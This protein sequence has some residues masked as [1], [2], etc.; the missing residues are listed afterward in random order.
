MKKPK[1]VK[2]RREPA[3]RRLLLSI[4]VIVAV[5]ICAVALVL[6]FSPPHEELSQQSEQPKAALLDTLEPNPTFTG[7]VVECLEE[8]GYEVDIYTGEEVTVELLENF[9]KGYALIIFRLH[10]ALYEDEGL[11]IFT[12]EPYSTREY[13]REQLA[14]EVKEALVYEG[15]E[16]FFAISQ[17]FVKHYMKGKIGD[18]IIVAM[19]CHTMA[20][21]LMPNQFIHQGAK[22][23]IGWSGL[24]TLSH[25][26]E[27]VSRLLENLCDENLTVGE[28]VNATATEVG[29]DP[30]YGTQL[31]YQQAEKYS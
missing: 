4:S 31:L 13:V 27:A 18:A 7:K 22:A 15:G 21:P 2:M 12:G 8:A 1:H 6:V 5:S 10:S 26:D 19:G 3:R 20:D 23:Y 11:Y 14:G 24:V 30:Y 9:P 25:A 29:P 28:A 16:S 17:A